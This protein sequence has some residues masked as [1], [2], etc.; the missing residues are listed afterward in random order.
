MLI[1]DSQVH[2]WINTQMAP[3]HRQVP[4]FTAEDLIAEM[5][6]AGVDRVILHPPGVVPNG[7]ESRHR[8]RQCP[9][10]PVQGPRLGP[11]GSARDRSAAEAGRLDATHRACSA[12]ASSSSRPAGKHWPPGRHAGLDLAHRQRTEKCPS[13]CS[14]MISC[15]RL[16]ELAD[17]YP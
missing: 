11:Y 2:I 15:P 3:I 6:E 1:V 8:R 16:G 14:P 4:N 5:D 13:A 10:R 12:C 9:S 17:Q 7:N